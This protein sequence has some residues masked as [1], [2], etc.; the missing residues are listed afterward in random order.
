M[1]DQITHRYAQV[2]QRL[3]VV[4]PGGQVM[5]LAVSKKHNTKAI[6][7]LYHVG[8]HRFAE[9]YVQ[10]ATAKMAKLDDLDIEWHFIGH[11]QSNK[12]QVIAQHFD[13]VQSVSRMKILCQLAKYRSVEKDPLKILLQLKIGNEDSKSGASVSELIAI[14]KTARTLPSVQ[15][16]GLMCIPPPSSQEAIQMHHFKEAKTLFDKLQISDPNI[17]TLSMGMSGDLEIAVQCGSTMVRIGTDI[18]GARI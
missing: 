14:Y 5:L 2:K 4:D 15:V 6:R 3:A 17:D 1:D 10:E 8:Q 18:F 11:I 16:R 9:N 12:T 7:S 13:W